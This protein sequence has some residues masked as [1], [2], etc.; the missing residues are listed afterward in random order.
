MMIE[1]VAGRCGAGTRAGAGLWRV[2]RVGR[3]DIIDQKQVEKGKRR[4]GGRNPKAW[5][6]TARESYGHGKM[7]V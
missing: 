7:I 6:R 5:S 3:G 4:P 2:G 1:T